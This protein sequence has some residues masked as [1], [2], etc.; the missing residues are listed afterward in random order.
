MAQDNLGQM[1]ENGDARLPHDLVEAYKWYW[2]SNLQGN[3]TGRHD[4]LVIE[5]H[6]ALAPGQIAEAKRMAGEFRAQT[7]TNR[8]AEASMQY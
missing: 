4:V 7:H 5:L 3:A 1:Y 8:L 6:H 2:L